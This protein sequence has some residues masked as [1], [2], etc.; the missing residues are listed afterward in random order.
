MD[1]LLEQL[2]RERIATLGGTLPNAIQMVSSRSKA[3][4]QKVMAVH[5]ECGRPILAAEG[6]ALLSRGIF[7]WADEGTLRKKHYPECDLWL[8][9]ALVTLTENCCPVATVQMVG[10]IERNVTSGNRASRRNAVEFLTY[11]VLPRKRSGPT[12]STF[13][14][15]APLMHWLRAVH[16]IWQLRLRSKPKIRNLTVSQGELG[17]ITRPIKTGC[18]ETLAPLLAHA[19]ESLHAEDRSLIERVIYAG[20]SQE[21]IAYER[22][23]HPG[24]ITRQKQRIIR[25][26]RIA[27]L[28]AL[29]LAGAALDRQRECID[30]FSPEPKEASWAL[31]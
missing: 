19:L 2:A 18:P 6:I 11:L 15:V 16:R 21:A 23:V 1:R 8:D 14:G 13:G 4:L 7:V 31:V 30:E 17:A 10:L 22:G 20:E 5:A 29:P 3:A 27:M 26:L 12:L 24:Q 28:A 25:D 9:L